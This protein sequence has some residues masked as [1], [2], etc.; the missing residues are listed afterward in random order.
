[1]LL[2]VTFYLRLLVF[3]IISVFFIYLINESYVTNNWSSTRRMGFAEAKYCS[4]PVYSMNRIVVQEFN[5]SLPFCYRTEG[6]HYFMCMSDDVLRGCEP[7]LRHVTVGSS[8]EEF[9]DKFNSA[10]RNYFPN[11]AFILLCSIMSM[12]LSCMYEAKE[13][14]EENPNNPAVDSMFMI[15]FNVCL[16]LAVIL[17]LLI[18]SAQFILIYTED[19]T[20]LYKD[21][22]DSKFCTN[23]A[24]CHAVINSVI[25]PPNWFV[26]WY[27]WI[28]LVFVGMIVTTLGLM[29]SVKYS[30]SANMH[31][32]HPGTDDTSLEEPVLLPL[33]FKRQRDW[34]NTSELE[35]SSDCTCP[36]CLNRINASQSVELVEDF[37]EELSSRER[38]DLGGIVQL[39]CKHFFHHD[40]IRQWSEMH[41]TCPVCRLSLFRDQ[42]SQ[43]DGR[44]ETFS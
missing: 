21:A 22:N 42:V 19:C 2:V 33:E 38:A 3:T 10:E 25:D 11:C 44:P 5:S 31:Q 39:P 4:T 7:V 18:T 30:I 35:F 34:R 1:M 37:D 23:M 36:I 12:G 32:V 20:A 9:N 29:C 43:T 24:S 8:V 6:S 14:T 17:S 15:R 28:C 27:R 26:N 40:C 41:E 13:V 16:S